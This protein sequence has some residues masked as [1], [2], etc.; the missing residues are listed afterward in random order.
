M[1]GIQ[2]GSAASEAQVRAVFGRLEHPT[3][4]D[5]DGR[6]V[7][8]GSRPRSFR[9][10][11]EREAEALAAEPD[12]TEERRA[13]IRNKVYA[14]TPQGRGLL[15]PDVRPG[16]VGER[17]LDRAAAGRPR[18]RRRRTWS[19]RTAPGWPRRWPTSS[20][21]PGTCG[22]GITARRCPGSRSGSTS[23]P[24]GWPGS[25]GTTPPAAPS[26]RTCT[27]TSRWSTGPRRC[28]MASCARWPAGGSGRSSRP[29]TRSTP[30]PISGCSASRTGWC[31]PPA[32]TGRPRRSSGSA[33]SCWPRPQRGGW[34]WN[35]DGISWW[36]SSSKTAAAPPH[37]LTASG[38]TGRRGARP[39]RP[40]TTRWRRGSS[41]RTGRRRCAPRSTRR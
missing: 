27:A 6:P 23:R 15:R 39:G 28:R 38:C 20:G 25:A 16:Q 41:W 24:A 12:A 18:P 21:R 29:P 33:R 36:R 3:Q 8:L 4:R 14:D 2:A 5:A 13:Q 11:A 35:A 32:A 31:S 37:R 17:V 9:S 26:S 19:R 40:R 30:R 34:T 10:R 7:S 1:L 22:R